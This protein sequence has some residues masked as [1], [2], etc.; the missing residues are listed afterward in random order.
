[1]YNISIAEK[2]VLSKE[3]QFLE[4][5]KYSMHETTRSCPYIVPA[6]HYLCSDLPSIWFRGLCKPGPDID[7]GNYQSFGFE[8]ASKIQCH[9]SLGKE[10]ISYYLITCQLATK[11]MFFCPQSILVF[12][13]KQWRSPYTLYPAWATAIWKHTSLSERSLLLQIRVT[14]LFHTCRLN[15]TT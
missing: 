15:N 13:G 9:N 14:L 11:W 1:M 4:V 12:L 6:P 10:A 2:R 8:N 7:I 3:K 5:L